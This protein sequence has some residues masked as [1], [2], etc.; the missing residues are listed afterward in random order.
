MRRLL[1]FGSLCQV[2][3]FERIYVCQKIPFLGISYIFL[4]L[5]FS[6]SAEADTPDHDVGTSE[7]KDG[8]QLSQTNST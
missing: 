7:G 8:F 1:V 4:I 5:N 6:A 3:H 2:F